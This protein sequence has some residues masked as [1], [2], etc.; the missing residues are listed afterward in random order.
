MVPV[1]A[2]AMEMIRRA[3][4]DFISL[5]LVMPKKS[6]HKLL[7]ELRK[8]RQLSRI[9][10]LI[11]TAHAQDELGAGDLQDIMDNRVISGPG[12][13]L[14][15]EEERQRVRPSPIHSE[16]ERTEGNGKEDPHR[17]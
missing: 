2:L 16:S 11:V 6:G 1:M 10:V 17:G 12:V 5:D 3:P 4:T 7:H 13:Y 9:P 15:K 8:D 14:E